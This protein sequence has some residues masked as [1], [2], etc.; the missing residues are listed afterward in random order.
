MDS[1]VWTAGRVSKAHS[2][3]LMLAGKRVIQK[4]TI[5]QLDILHQQTNVGL[6]LHLWAALTLQTHTHTHTHVLNIFC[7]HI[8][9]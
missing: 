6:P 7:I 8:N 3:A 2:F 5:A 4:E 9:A 1:Q